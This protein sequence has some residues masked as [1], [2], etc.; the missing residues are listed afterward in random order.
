MLKKIIR[1]PLWFPLRILIMF[2]CMTFMYLGGKAENI[3]D[4]CDENMWAIRKKI[5]NDGKDK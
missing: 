1:F 5:Q 3:F 2:F 4:W